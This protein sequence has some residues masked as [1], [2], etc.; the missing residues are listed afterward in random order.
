MKN[1]SRVLSK[2]NLANID[3]LKY[4][5]D[6]ERSE[7]R[8]FWKNCVLTTK[9]VQIVQ[10]EHLLCPKVGGHKPSPTPLLTFYA[11]CRTI[12]NFMASNFHDCVS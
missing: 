4:C 7:P 6:G 1:Y 3:L 9:Y 2:Q 5:K 8:K 10:L 12:Y 11:L